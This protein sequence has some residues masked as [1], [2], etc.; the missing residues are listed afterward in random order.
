M[1]MLM[2]ADRSIER[3]RKRRTGRNSSSL[4]KREKMNIKYIRKKFECTD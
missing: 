2:K 1:A 3:K 4:R